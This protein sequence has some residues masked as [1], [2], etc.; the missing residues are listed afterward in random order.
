MSLKKDLANAIN[1]IEKEIQELERKR[2]RSMAAIMESIISKS[3]PQEKDVH[4][5]RQ[6]SAEI[7][8]KREELIDITEQ[9]KR[10]V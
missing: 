3:E 2:I 1:Y 6:Y 10:L 4:Y 9:L 7:D 5:F 8:Q